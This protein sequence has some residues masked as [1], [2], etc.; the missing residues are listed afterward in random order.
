MVRFHD[1]KPTGIW[2][3]QHR[4]G[5]V[6]QW[7][8]AGLS[9]ENDRVCVIFLGQEVHGCL[10]YRSPSSLVPMARTQTTPVQGKC[11]MNALL[12]IRDILT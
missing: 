10:T 8:D 9:L 4:D 2:Y 12:D 7:G 1:G 11:N 3:S 5:A 6:Y